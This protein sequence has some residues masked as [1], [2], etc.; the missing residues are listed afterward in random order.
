LIYRVWQL[1]EET[2]LTEDIVQEE[3][4]KVTKVE[5]KEKFFIDVAEDGAYCVYGPEIE[6]H[7]KRTQ[8][9]NE[10]SMNRFLQIVES[11]GVIKEL[12]K[13]GIQDGDTVRIFE[14]EFDFLD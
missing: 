14:L 3:E 12:R 11:M 6:R 7:Y 8:F 9:E 1:V 10:D 4:V 2:V 5:E 13:A